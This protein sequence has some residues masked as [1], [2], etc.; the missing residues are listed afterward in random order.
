MEHEP[1]FRPLEHFSDDELDSITLDLQA[2][3]RDIDET[4]GEVLSERARRY[5]ERLRH[6]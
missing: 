3:R 4:Y 6:E 1:R 2:Q 5:T